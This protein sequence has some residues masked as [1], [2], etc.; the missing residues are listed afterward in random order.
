M[1]HTAYLQ[2]LHAIFAQREVAYLVFL[3]DGDMSR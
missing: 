3:S 1:F 2:V